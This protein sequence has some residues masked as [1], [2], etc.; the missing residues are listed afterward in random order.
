MS[1]DS[2]PESALPPGYGSP[3]A[4]HPNYRY[5]PY[6]NPPNLVQPTVRRLSDWGTP[7]PIWNMGDSVMIPLDKPNI[8]TLGKIVD[9]KV[10]FYKPGADDEVKK[11][12]PAQLGRLEP[13]YDVFVEP[14]LRVKKIP[15]RY[16]VPPSLQE[17][18]WMNQSH[19]K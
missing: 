7:H 15:E 19:F 12:S 4:P 1:S 11:L 6:Y 14:D 17:R 13:V 3:I 8:W 18:L 9:R 2:N 10:Q 5:D 16:L